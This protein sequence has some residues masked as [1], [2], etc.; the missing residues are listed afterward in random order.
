M[1][2][3]DKRREAEKAAVFRP[4]PSEADG[5]RAERTSRTRARSTSGSRRDR[6]KDAGLRRKTPLELGRVRRM[7]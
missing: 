4:K 7:G 5:E 1:P 2:A 3:H 6:P